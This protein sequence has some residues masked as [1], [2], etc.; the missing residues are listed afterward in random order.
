MTNCFSST[1]RSPPSC[2]TS[3]TMSKTWWTT[4][5]TCWERSLWRCDT[6]GL[7]EELWRV[8]VWYLSRG[9]VVRH[10]VDELA[11]LRRRQDG[12]L[13]VDV[14]QWDD[15]A[16]RVLGEVFQFHPLALRD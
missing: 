1:T 5:G 3:G 12:L 15:E 6:G 14:P 9:D 8:D 16:A 7:T 13:W 10:A 4:C 11:T 2:P